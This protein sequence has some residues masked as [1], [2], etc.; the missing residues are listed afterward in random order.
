V[1]FK[2]LS[3]GLC[4]AP[5]TFA[6]LMDQVLAGVPRQQCLVY[7]DDIL[8]H[9]CSFEA[10]LGSLRLVLEWISAAGLKLHPAKCYFMQRWVSFLGHTGGRGHQYPKGQGAGGSRLAHPH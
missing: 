10:T 6:R 3:F 4:N 2:V 1:A 9:G 5:A 7:L 8:A